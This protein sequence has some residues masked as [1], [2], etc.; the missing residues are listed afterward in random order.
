M[1]TA[2]LMIEQG[3]VMYDYRFPYSMGLTSPKSAWTFVSPR[4]SYEVIH[5]IIVSLHC[6][7]VR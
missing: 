7:G 6:R 5:N 3:R 1:I 4:P 2:A